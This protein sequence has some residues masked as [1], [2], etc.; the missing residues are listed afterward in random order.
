[1]RRR[2]ARW[3]I[4]ALTSL[5]PFFVGD[6]SPA[7]AYGPGPEGIV[8]SPDGKWAYVTNSASQAIE[9]ID[10]ATDQL[11]FR[12]PI[13]TG[14]YFV[15]GLAIS[16]DGKR[17]YVS[18]M[19]RDQVLV[20]DTGERKVVAAVKVGSV[21]VGVGLSP[22]GKRLYVANQDDDTVSVIDTAT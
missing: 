21:P 5:L 14:G 2:F 13:D 22:D 15:P 11:A 19:A 16:P 1:M 10:T 9:V 6:L 20:I 8:V 12:M 17:L 4:L 3:A 7:W 18:I